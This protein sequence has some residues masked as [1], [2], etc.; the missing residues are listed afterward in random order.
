MSEESLRR[1]VDLPAAGNHRYARGRGL[2]LLQGL[3]AP[4]ER[5]HQTD[6]AGVRVAA[7]PQDRDLCPQF[8]AA[9]PHT[10]RTC[11]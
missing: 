8:S 7:F 1:H 6:V 10:W 9:D 4:P 11:R 3:C 2:L 5:G